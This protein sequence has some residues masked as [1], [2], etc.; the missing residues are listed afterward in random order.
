MAK[1]KIQWVKQY[2][3]TCVLEF[4]TFL[5]YPLQNNNVKTPTFARPVNGNL[6]GKSLKFTL[7]MLK[8][9]RG[10]IRDN[11]YIQPFAKFLLKLYFW[12]HFERVLRTHFE[13]ALN[14]FTSMRPMINKGSRATLFFD[15][16]QNWNHSRLANTL[17]VRFD[18]FFL[19]VYNTE[20]RS[21]NLRLRIW[22]ETKIHSV[23][24]YLRWILHLSF[25]LVVLILRDK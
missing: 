3:R 11:K 4:C 17:P 10:A 16:M 1:L 18:F 19:C 20:Y 2:L 15:E 23:H 25:V 7:D 12:T 6:D 22:V 21:G 9:R 14:R 5:I 24:L 13:P 8:L